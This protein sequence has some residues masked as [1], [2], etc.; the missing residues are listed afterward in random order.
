MNVKDNLIKIYN[1]Y[2]QL[3]FK[4]RL[5]LL[6][7]VA[8]LFRLVFSQQLSMELDTHYYGNLVRDIRNNI[9]T[10]KIFSNPIDNAHYYGIEFR[11]PLFA[12]VSTLFYIITGNA[13]LSLVLVSLLCG[14]LLV[15][16]VFLLARRIWGDPAG[17]LATLIIIPFPL[18]ILVSTGGLTESLYLLL[19]ATSVYFSVIAF[20]SGK[21]RDYIL[22]AVFWG[23]AYLTRFEALAAA[24]ATFF[25]FLMRMMGRWKKE[26]IKTLLGKPA[27]FVIIVV[28]IM[29]PY[30]VI[31]YK[32]SGSFHLTSPTK[33]LY[34][35]NEAYWIIS[36]EEGSYTTLNYYYG[37][38]GE[39]SFHQLKK[40]IPKQPE[41]IFRENLKIFIPAISRA[42]PINLWTLI[43]DFNMFIFLILLAMPFVRIGKRDP[44]TTAVI[45]YSITAIPVILLSFWAPDPRYYSF[46]IPILAILSGGALK[47]IF[48]DERGVLV[49]DP[50]WR[51]RLSWIM[52]PLSL[53]ISWYFYLSEALMPGWF[54]FNFRLLGIALHKSLMILLFLFVGSGI[55]TIAFTII[56][57][58]VFW[59]LTIP[60]AGLGLLLIYGGIF[61]SKP[62]NPVELSSFLTGHFFYTVR[63]ILL[64]LVALGLFY[65]GILY[66]E[67]RFKD[68][69]K[70]QK[71][72]FAFSLIV[73]FLINIQNIVVINQE[74][75]AYRYRNYHP[76]AVREI[77]EKVKNSP[78]KQKTNLAVMCRHP[79][80]AFALKARWIRI[81]PIYNYKEFEKAFKQNVPDYII[82]DNLSQKEGKQQSIDPLFLILKEKGEIKKLKYY[83]KNNSRYD[84]RKIRVWVYENTEDGRRK[85][86]AGSR[87]EECRSLTAEVIRK[88]GNNGKEVGS[89]RLEAGSWKCRHRKTKKIPFIEGLHLTTE[90]TESTEDTEISMFFLRPSSAKS[91]LSA[92]KKTRKKYAYSIKPKTSRGIRYPKSSVFSLYSV[93]SVMNYW[94]SFHRDRRNTGTSPFKG[95]GKS[96]KIVWKFKARHEIFSSPVITKQGLI[97]FGCDDSNIY[98][99]TS[100]GKLKWKYKA[101]YYVSASP[102]VS[103]GGIVYIGSD[104][105]HLYAVN[106]NGKIKWRFKTGYFISSGCK[107]N[108]KGN[109]IFGGEDGFVYCLNSAGKCVWK[110]KTGGE[111][112]G[113]PAIWEGKGSKT[114]ANDV[115]IATCGDGNIYAIS[116]NGKLLWK[117]KTGGEIVSSPAIDRDGT[118]YA[119]SRDGYLYA[120]K[121][122]GKLKWRYGTGGEIASSPAVGKN[123]KI[124]FGSSDGNIYAVSRSGKLYWKYKTGFRVESSPAIDSKGYIYIGSHDRHIYGISKKGKLLWKIKTGGAVY[125]SPAISPDGSIYVGSMDKY[126]YKIK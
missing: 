13:E 89:R 11:P 119:G 18:L 63:A 104:D 111:V 116:G 78:H 114:G 115:V 49:K 94:D 120:V 55:L 90:I 4:K 97:I 76:S 2:I 74:R 73:L 98:A 1:R 71:V 12:L 64:W 41:Q 19:F 110:Y 123:G 125:S 103:S 42:I 67:K 77:K 52:I 53:F 25:L 91:A 35:M 7:I 46:M 30:L 51:F 54:Q 117:Y 83:E 75:T 121:K 100:K 23:L 6:V 118:I 126:L 124:V 38:P 106:S 15:V 16:P 3:D 44:R 72:L 57:K 9:F 36:E 88:S 84:Y 112:I 109:I 45:M 10:G 79:R 29:S 85:T 39:Y 20:E 32:T 122:N 92:L 69:V 22:S 43:R 87:N 5:L 60:T 48:E 17:D 66:I 58:R 59:F 14:C 37:S 31:L 113:T 21:W 62:A 108:K 40:L 101:D 86:E 102:A 95:P 47:M 107:I 28:L 68:P 80:D 65:E 96:A 82:L 33:E 81:P 24:G 8:L 70:Y 50:R 61:A 26:N 93:S 56:W 34:D 27:I 105:Q 99:I